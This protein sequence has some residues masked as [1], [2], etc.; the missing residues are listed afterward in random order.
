MLEFED[1]L[2]SHSFY[3]KGNLGMVH[4]Y[5]A[6]HKN[7]A[8]KTKEEIAYDGMTKEVMTHLVKST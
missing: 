7:P 6:M 2:G 5:L 3:F 4:T 8:P 1:T